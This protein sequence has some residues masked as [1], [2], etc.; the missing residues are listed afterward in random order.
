MYNE[1][2]DY[3]DGS[4][5]VV[6]TSQLMRNGRS[7]TFHIIT[8]VRRGGPTSQLVPMCSKLACAFHFVHQPVYAT[9]KCESTKHK[10]ITY[11]SHIWNTP[12]YH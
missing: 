1:Q 3:H 8:L 7:N 10:N 4:V 12:R 5:Q 6:Q 9:M 2:P 11:M